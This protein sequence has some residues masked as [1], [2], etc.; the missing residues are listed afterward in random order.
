MP[1]TTATQ[2]YS[3]PRSGRWAMSSTARCQAVDRR[4]LRQQRDRCLGDLGYE[5]A[6]LSGLASRQGLIRPPYLAAFCGLFHRGSFPGGRTSTL[7][8]GVIPWA[9]HSFVLT[10]DQLI[11]RADHNSPSGRAMVIDHTLVGN[12]HPRWCVSPPNGRRPGSPC[13]GESSTLIGC[14]LLEGRPRGG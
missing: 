2:C 13:T 3:V 7:S 12:V 5:F 11:R 6:P 14:H 1:K 8:H 10:R 4:V 9:G